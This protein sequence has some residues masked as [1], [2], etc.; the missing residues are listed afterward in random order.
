MDFIK[1]VK[2]IVIKIGSS[3]LTHSTGRLNLHRIEI[4]ARVLSDFK[5]S[6]KE[7]ILVTSAAISAG[8]AKLG[9]DHRPAT[10][11]EKQAMA[12]VGQ[13]ELMTIY[14]RFFRMYGHTVGQI[15]ITRDTV[16]N[17]VSRKNA[18]NTFNTLLKMGCIPVV[19]ENDTISFEEIEFGDNDTLAAYVALLCRA[20]ILVNLSDIN[21]LYDSDP[22][23]NQDA[24]LIPTVVKIDDNIRAAAGG[25]G[26]DFGTGG[27]ITKLHAAEIACSNG[28]PMFIINGE[29]PEIMYDLFEGRHIGT[30]FMPY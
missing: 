9:L 14:E 26:S 15:L 5:N 3:S 2:R 27:V 28:I 17:P 4:L 13:C 21:G 19:N 12:A 6:G 7:I 30:Y 8:K 29:N 24:K 18:E 10:I 23:K 22:H 20:D 11:E 16:N 1:N 25:A